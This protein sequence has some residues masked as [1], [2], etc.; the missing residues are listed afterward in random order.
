MFANDAENDQRGGE[1]CAKGNELTALGFKKIEKVAR[2]HGWSM[3]MG[4]TV[5]A[6]VTVTTGGG[7]GGERRVTKT[8]KAL[9]KDNSLRPPSGVPLTAK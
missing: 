8:V 2:F 6:L 1:H 3:W 4:W 5:G 7:G 9:R